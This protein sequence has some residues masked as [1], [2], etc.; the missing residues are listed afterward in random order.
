[1]AITQSP[2]RATSLLPKATYSKGLSASI[3]STAMSMFASV[4][5]ILAG[6]ISPLMNS[7]SISSAPSITWLFVTTYPSSLITK[8]AP[9]AEALR[10]PRCPLLGPRNKSS[11]GLPSGT[12][13]WGP[14]GVA[15]FVVVV[16]FTTAPPTCSTRS[17]KVA[18]APR[19]AAARVCIHNNAT[20]A[21]NVNDR[22]ARENAGRV[23]AIALEVI[24]I[25]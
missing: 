5:T 16:I 18:G 22:L 3:F 25:F 14:I 7:T 15:I 12:I 20:K 23:C 1:M 4:P 11:N 24:C 8:P 9:N 2:T 6:K 17:A 10:G 21:R 19:A 13:P